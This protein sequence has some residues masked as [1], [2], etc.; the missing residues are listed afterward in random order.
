M[1]PLP[2]PNAMQDTRAMS[3]PSLSPQRILVVDDDPLIL[4]ALRLVLESDRHLVTTACGGAAGIS[5]VE[6]A[7]AAREPYFVVMTDLNMPSIDGHQ[8]AKAVKTLTPD[9]P[10]VLMTGAI[11]PLSADGATVG[12]VDMLLSKPPNRTE[13]RMMLQALK[14]RRESAGLPA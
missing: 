12:G 2:T 10:V 3:Q 8:V 13:L 11:D 9:T 7:V 6:S 1:R 4:K 14:E 5:A